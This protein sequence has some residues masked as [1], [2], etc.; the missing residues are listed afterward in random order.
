[1]R[2]PFATRRPHVAG[3][4]HLEPPV[5]HIVA[6]LDE[7]DAE[8]TAR[9]AM[10]VVLAPR[11]SGLRLLARGAT[12]LLLLAA[13][14]CATTGATVG[15]GVGD[16]F[17]QR[18]P[19]YA[20]ASMPG[21]AA[22]TS[23]IG[24]LPVAYQRGAAQLSIFDPTAGPDTPVGA[25]LG[26]MNAFL[27]S[28]GGG[29]I[30]VRLVEGQRVSAVAHAETRR[31]PDV[32]F[33]CITESGRPDDDEC[34]ERPG[35]LGRGK[36]TMHLAVANPAPEWRAWVR[37]VMRD[38]GVGRTLVLTL[39]VGQYPVRQRGLGAKSVELGTGHVAPIPWLT[40]L[41]TPVQVLQLTGALVDPNGRAI[42][43]GAEGIAARRTRL[44][45]S[46]V[47]GTELLSD[48]DVE[49][50]RTLRRDDLPGRPLAWQV[51]LRHLVTQL[52]GRQ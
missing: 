14:A 7:I 9:A 25:L 6:D 32:R 43:I 38:V 48:E 39:E 37:D 36:Q 17:P 4:D 5:A 13:T 50:V 23:R 41:E 26:E 20:G 33:G 30:S 46:A 15:S 29:R 10:R 47:G 21:V 22:D 40:S 2:L 27:D 28:L 24:H 1:M 49:R 35:A 44:L 51:A 11:R 45:V 52:T 18:A 34:V 31:P 42:R 16:A 8:E 19:F 12:A 3:A